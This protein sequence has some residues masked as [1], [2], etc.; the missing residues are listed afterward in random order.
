MSG[1]LT[2]AQS[3][4]AQT[5]SPPVENFLATVLHQTTLDRL[6]LTGYTIADY[7]P[8]NTMA[9]QHLSRTR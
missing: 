2:Q 6:K 4:P 5:Q 8:G 9:L 1:S 3:S 7:I